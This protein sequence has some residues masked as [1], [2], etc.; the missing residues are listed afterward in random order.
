MWDASDAP[1]ADATMM[2]IRSSITAPRR[3][4][5]STLIKDLM[6]QHKGESTEATTKETKDQ[7]LRKRETMLDL[8]LDQRLKP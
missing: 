7:L 1:S 8:L 3:E 5:W 2:E 6:E 4:Q